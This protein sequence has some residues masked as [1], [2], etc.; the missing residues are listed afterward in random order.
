MNFMKLQKE[1]LKEQALRE[2]EQSNST[3]RNAKLFE[4]LRTLMSIELNEGYEENA[5][6]Q[7]VEESEETQRDMKLLIE[8]FEQL[9]IEK[10]KLETKDVCFIHYQG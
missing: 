9:L 4:E 2:L 1:Q 5:V 6:T 7:V 10:E 3:F 8:E